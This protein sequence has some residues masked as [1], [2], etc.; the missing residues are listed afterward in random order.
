M[1]EPIQYPP[2][3]GDIPLS[4]PALTLS[5]REQVTDGHGGIPKTL[6]GRAGQPGPPSAVTLRERPAATPGQIAPTVPVPPAPAYTP[7]LTPPATPTQA[8]P[9]PHPRLVVLRGQRVN[10]EYPVYEGRNTIGR[11]AD[12]PV[13]IDLLSQ[14]AEGQV[15]SSR[16]HAAITFDRGLLLI[17]DLNSL[18]GTWVNGARVH[19]GQQRM[20]KP[21]DVIQ[22]GNV[23]LK[24][25]VG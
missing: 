16:Q 1:V 9:Q 21:N 15:W 23:Q 13:D 10:A 14:E 22:I 17:E 4:C 19:A 2:S 25:V 5:L 7:T 6:T 12:K 3:D 24:L 20:L 8:G 11:F 18:N